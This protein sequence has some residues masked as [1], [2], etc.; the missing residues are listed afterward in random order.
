MKTTEASTNSSSPGV[1][2]LGMAIG[3][4]EFLLGPATFVKHGLA[5]LWVTLVPCSS[6]PSSTPSSCGTRGDG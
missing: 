6:R 3:S 4:G 1:I 5:L 2:V